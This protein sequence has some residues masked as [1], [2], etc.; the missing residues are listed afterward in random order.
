MSF[1]LLHRNREIRTDIIALMA[2]DAIVRTR[3]FAFDMVVEFQH[4]LRTYPHAQTAA[5]APGL[6][7]SDAETLCQKNHLPP[8]AIAALMIQK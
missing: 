2:T 1:T 4:L 3:W 7:D 5:F 6:V 8:L